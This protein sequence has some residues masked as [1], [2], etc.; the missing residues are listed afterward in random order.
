M[1]ETETHP[2]TIFIPEKASVLILGS[3]PGKDNIL[4]E[5]L[6]EWFYSAKRNQFWPILRRVY[7]EALLTTSEKK[8]L[9]IRKG[10]AIGDIYLRIKRKEKT[11]SDSSLE[12]VEYN[13]KAIRKALIKHSFR[14]IFTTSQSVEKE[15]KKLFPG[16]NH[17]QSLPSPSPRYARMSLEKKI[18]VYKHSLPA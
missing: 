17:I 16:I 10:I 7:E 6:D 11:N 18:A 9:F 1:T 3:F 8:S 4:V 2:H 5:G 14:N 15:F 12:V 13:D